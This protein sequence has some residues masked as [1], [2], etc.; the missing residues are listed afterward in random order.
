[1]FYYFQFLITVVCVI[2]ISLGAHFFKSQKMFE[3]IVFWVI[4]FGA[5]IGFVILYLKEFHNII[6]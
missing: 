3:A 5:L 4:A 1:M 6:F 2:C